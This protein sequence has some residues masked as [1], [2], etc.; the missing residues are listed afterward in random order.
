M[1]TIYQG[2]DRVINLTLT[3]EA[4]PAIDIN[5]LTG[6]V[7]FFVCTTGSKVWKKFSLNAIAGFDEISIVDAAAGQVSVKVQNADTVNAPEGSY[8]IE[9]KTSTENVDF[10]EASFE[11]ISKVSN[12]FC[13]ESVKILKQAT[14][15]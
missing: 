8:Q 9:V 14:S 1:E 12:A 7:I 2:E 13:I 15:V 4:G 11:S 6:L 5:S 10:N 3:S